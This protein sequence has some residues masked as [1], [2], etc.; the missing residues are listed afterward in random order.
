MGR[1]R[2]DHFSIVSMSSPNSV[3]N[4]NSFDFT[5]PLSPKQTNDGQRV[6]SFSIDPFMS[7]KKQTSIDKFI[8]KFAGQHQQH[9]GQNAALVDFNHKRET[10]N[11]FELVTYEYQS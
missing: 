7:K 11:G 4:P 3:N 8:F 1:N 10:S 9:N 6:R 5:S 2:A